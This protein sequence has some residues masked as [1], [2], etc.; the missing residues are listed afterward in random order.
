MRFGDDDTVTLSM[1][2]HAATP[3]ALLLSDDGNESHA[4]WVPRSQVVVAGT[5]QKDTDGEFTI[6]KWILEKNGLL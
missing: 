2:C 4:V 5:T 3:K 1:R 6:K